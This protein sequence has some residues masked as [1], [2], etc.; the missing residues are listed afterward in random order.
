[1]FIDEFL[2]IISTITATFG[3]DRLIVCGD[4]NLPGLPRSSNIDAD[5]HEAL[6]S[7]EFHQQVALPTRGDNILDILA[8]SDGIHTAG[9][10][11]S[12]AGFISDHRMILTS[13]P[14]KKRRTVNVTRISRNLSRINCLEFEKKL[15]ESEIFSSPANNV[16]DFCEPVKQLAS[17]VTRELDRVAPLKVSSKRKSKPGG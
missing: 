7:V 10:V 11:I 12:D 4:V 2:D 14:A 8:T 3:N 1:M 6:E 9:I 13:V 17:V 16:D 15:I 5:L